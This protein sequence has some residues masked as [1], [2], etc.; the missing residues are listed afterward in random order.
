MPR[1]ARAYCDVEESLLTMDHETK[2]QIVAAVM[3]GAT[4]GVFV[5]YCVLLRY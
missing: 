3:A 1:L 5:L 4:V 2:L